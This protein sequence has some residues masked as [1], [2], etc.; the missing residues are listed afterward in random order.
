MKTVADQVAVAMQRVQ[1]QSALREANARLLESDQRKNEFIAVLSH[2]LRNPLTPIGNSLYIL[3][4]APPGGN[5]ALRA[6]EV[7]ARQVNQLVHLVDDLLDVTRITRNKI[8][9]QRTRLDLCDVVRRSVEDQRSLFEKGELRLETNIPAAS[10]HVS[11]DATRVAQ[12]VS[13]LL[14]NAAKFSPRGGLTRVSLSCDRAQH[15]ATIRVADNGMGMAPQTLAGLFQPFMQADKTLDRSGGGLGLGL[16]LVRA[17][18]ELHGGQVHA[19][20]GGLGQ[21]AEFEVH[22]PLDEIA[23]HS[24]VSETANPPPQG[25]RVLIIEDNVD[26]A[27]SLR[28]ALRFGRHEVEV[29]YNGPDGVARARSF[30]PEVVLCDIGLPGMDGYDVARTLRAEAHVNQARLIAL[31]GYAL[32]QDL[33]RAHEAGFEGHLAKPP[34]MEALETLLANLGSGTQP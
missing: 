26:A 19:R 16:A 23:E 12:I 6:R 11:A 2:E 7:I 22:L 21:G 29:A 30:R 24:L 20:S 14:Q 32:P 34:R 33:Q 9:L 27:D 3:E 18:A 15:I 1:A 31:S 28:D 25:R 13:N 17:L 4:H 8:Q 10:I 5:Q